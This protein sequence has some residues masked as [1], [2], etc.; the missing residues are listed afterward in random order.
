MVPSG[1]APAVIL[2]KHTHRRRNT[3]Q[4]GAVEIR[5]GVPLALDRL[6]FMKATRTRFRFGGGASEQTVD[7]LPNEDDEDD[8]DDDASRQ[9]RRGMVTVISTRG[10][11]SERTRLLGRHQASPHHSA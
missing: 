11:P 7:R 1:L 4:E 10:R 2:G 5:S 3:E 9:E 6:S 8:E